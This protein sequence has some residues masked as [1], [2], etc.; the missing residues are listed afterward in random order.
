[1][2]LQIKSVIPVL[3]SYREMV[4]TYGLWDQIRVDQGKEW[5]LLLFINEHLSHLRN[6]C[7][8]PPHLQSSS[9]QV[10]ML[11]TFVMVKLKMQ[12]YCQQN[13]MVERIWVE[14][15]ARVNYPIKQVLV[16]MLDSGDFSLDREMHKFCVSWF[17]V[18]VASSGIELFVAAWN[19]HPIP[20]KNLR[21]YYDPGLFNIIIH[22]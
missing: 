16:D 6:D 9:K 15:N 17:T 18:Q 5:M 1:M 2:F 10:A 11:F 8:R 7:S 20:G 19:N 21:N 14:V 4:M 22:Y 13:H 12:M 3:L